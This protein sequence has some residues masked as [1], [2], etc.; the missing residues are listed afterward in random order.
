MAASQPSD[1]APSPPRPFQQ[2]SP[3]QFEVRE[4]GGC[5]SVLGLPFFVAGAVLTLAGV[6]FLPI[7]NASAGP[8][9]SRPVMVSMGFVFMAVGGT[10]V[11]GR[12]WTIVDTVQG[13]VTQSMRLLVPMQQQERA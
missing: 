5:L 4:G 11:A 3:G 1:T 13:L 2:I 12:R 6:G 10:L 9:W 7:Q 8:W